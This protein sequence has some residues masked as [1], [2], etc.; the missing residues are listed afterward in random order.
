MLSF[1]RLALVMVSPHSSKT[2][3]HQVSQG[4]N[5]PPSQT[6]AQLRLCSCLCCLLAFPGIQRSSLQSQLQSTVHRSE[7]PVLRVCT[8]WHSHSTWEHV[9]QEGFSRHP[10]RKQ[11]ERENGS[12]ELGFPKHLQ[13]HLPSNLSSS[14]S[15]FRGPTASL[16]YL[17]TWSF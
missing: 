7:P 17:N 9:A 16:W 10:G 4:V 8:D 6:K 14:R 12:K 3:R 15:H 11:R 2:L 5:L 13:G 1:V